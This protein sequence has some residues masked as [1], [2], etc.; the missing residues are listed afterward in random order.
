MP[1][2]DASFIEKNKMADPLSKRNSDS[3]MLIVAI[4]VAAGIAHLGTSTMPFQIG[5]LMDGRGLSASLAGIFGFFEIGAL[6]ISMILVSPVIHRFPLVWIAPGGAVVA[7]LAHA[8]MFVTP[9]DLVPLLASASFAGIGYGLVFA[10]AITGAST[11]FNPDRVYA[12]GNVGALIFIVLMMMIIP[13]ASAQLGAMG[14]FPA[15]AAL[16]A[17]VTPAMI[18]L[19]SRPPLKVATSTRVMSQPSSIALLLMWAAFSLGTGAL[20]S[21]AERIGTGLAIKPEMIGTILSGSTACGM[22]GSILAAGSSARISRSRA[23]LIG[24]VGTALACVVMGF[25]NGY[26]AFAL[27]VIAYWIFYMYQYALFLGTAA[28]L[29]PEGRLGTLGGGCERLAFAAGAPIGGVVVDNSSFGVLGLLGFVSCVALVPFC[30]PVISRA[31]TMQ[32]RREKSA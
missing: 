14:A 8:M 25:A 26:I 4:G 12:L 3:V 24:L 23:M 10:A 5:A 31:L 29:D 32:K 1:G 27:G 11:A 30:M 21:F 19:R 13:V 20:W 16:I 28:T 22:L 6:A 2:A 7:A 15:M 9:P 17:L 18:R